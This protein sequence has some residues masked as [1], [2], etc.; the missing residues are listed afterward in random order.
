M[1]LTTVDRPLT[2]PVPAGAHQSALGLNLTDIPTH[3]RVAAL[4]AELTERLT[5]HDNLHSFQ[6]FITAAHRMRTYSISNQLLLWSQMAHVQIAFGYKS[7]AAHG[8]HVRAGEKGLKIFAPVTARRTNTDTNTPPSNETSSASSSSAS[9]K[10]RVVV[11]FKLATVFDISQT[12]ISDGAVDPLQVLTPATLTGDAPA[13]VLAAL[14]AIIGGDG[15]TLER[16]ECHGADGYTDFRNRTVRIRD[17]IDDAHALL[18]AAHELA[19]VRLH[20]PTL[21]VERCRG[22]NEVEAESVASLIATIVGIDSDTNSLPYLSGWASSLVD[23]DHSLLD[24]FTTTAQRVIEC[25]TTITDQIT[26]LHVM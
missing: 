7:W 18:V 25:A 17:D 6:S 2:G 9:S 5:G 13:G 24:I 14:L 11:G 19:H 10:D 26:A 21:I 4:H 1:S 16:G 15:F 8:R 20:E 23:Q 12:D 22:R 3:D